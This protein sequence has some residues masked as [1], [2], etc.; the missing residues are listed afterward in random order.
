MGLDQIFQ[1]GELFN[2]SPGKRK[3]CCN[4]YLFLESCTNLDSLKTGTV[5]KNPETPESVAKENW[6]FKLCA[7]GESFE[8]MTTSVRESCIKLA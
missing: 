6:R 2:S 4:K 7:S 8:I 3:Q 5:I 1:K